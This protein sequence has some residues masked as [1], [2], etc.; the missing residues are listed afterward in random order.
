MENPEGLLRNDKYQVFLMSCQC[1]LI[2]CFAK[3][4]WFVVNNKGKISRWEVLM[5]NDLHGKGWGH[6]HLNAHK[7]FAAFGT[8]T[9][10]GK[11]FF[12]PDLLGYTEGDEDSL[13]EKM[14]HFINNSPHTYPHCFDYF[15][16]SPNSNT[17]VQWVLD[18]FPEFPAKMSW[19]AFG[20]GYKVGDKS[21]AH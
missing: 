10:H 3:H 2:L 7:P 6:L 13:A 17:Y 14:V 9:P 12:K 19:N 8:L 4:H 15:L 18:Q 1:R 5:E 20:K 21:K 16:G 11:P